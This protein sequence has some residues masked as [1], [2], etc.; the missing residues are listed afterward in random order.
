LTARDSLSG[1]IKA[2]FDNQLVKTNKALIEFAE[3]VIKDDLL[4]TRLPDKV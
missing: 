3:Q 2:R 1:L 4:S